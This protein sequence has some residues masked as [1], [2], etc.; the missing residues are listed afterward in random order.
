MNYMDYPDDPCMYM[1]TAGQA[2]RMEAWMN[3][4]LSRNL[5]TNVLGEAGQG[6]AT[7]DNTNTTTTDN[8]DTDNTSTT[9]TDN[10]STDTDNTE[11]ET[12]EGTST[13]TMKVTLDEFGSETTFAILDDEGYI[14][15]EYGPFQ[16]DQDGK[17]ITRSIDL[18]LI[19]I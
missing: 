9:T 12:T 7:T 3:S 19:H 13:I 11:E 6:V 10:T 1:F 15:E 4:N 17:V 5:K 18:S 2:R 8:T 14:I 16:D